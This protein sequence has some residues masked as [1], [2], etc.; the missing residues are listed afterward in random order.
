MNLI[1]LKYF[2]EWNGGKMKKRNIPLK[3]YI[4]L[5][6]IAFATIF[7]VFYLRSW[8]NASKEYYQ[9]NSIM[10]KYLSELKSEEIN[11]YILD[12]PEVVIYYASA[13]DTNIKSF[14]KSFKKLMEQYEIKENIIYIDSSKAE[15]NELISVLNSISDKKAN[16]LIVP[17]L[18]YIKNS[19]VN[20]ILYSEVT[21]INRR[22]V[23]NFLIKVGVITND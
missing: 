1:M 5:L 14:E 17:N 18:I 8:Y 21:E 6:L 4:T 15:N 23:R 3:N 13:R 16:S 19:R 10:S 7:L 9:N 11:S 2:I 20:K 12:N 22:D